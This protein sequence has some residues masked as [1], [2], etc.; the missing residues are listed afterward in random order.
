[1]PSEAVLLELQIL[2]A[3]WLPSVDFPSGPVAKASQ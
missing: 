1:M 3:I 2:Q